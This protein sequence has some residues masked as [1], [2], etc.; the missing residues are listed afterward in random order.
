MT[1]SCNPYLY[2][3]VWLLKLFAIDTRV[4]E[5]DTEE[6]AVQGFYLSKNI[7]GGKID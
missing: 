7:G 2:W 5:I 6:R 3:I 4:I 1:K